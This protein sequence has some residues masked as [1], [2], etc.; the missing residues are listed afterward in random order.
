MRVDD[1]EELSVDQRKIRKIWSDISE[2][3]YISTNKDGDRINSF[4][5][6]W[7]LATGRRER[8]SKRYTKDKSWNGM[9]KEFEIRTNDDGTFKMKEMLKLY[10]EMK[11][12]AQIYLR[13]INT[14]HALW[15]ENPYDKAVCRDERNYLRIISA[16]SA[17]IQHIPPVMCLINHVEENDY[18]RDVIRRFLK[19]YNYILLRYKTIPVLVDS[20]PGI[21]GGDIYSK[22]Q[23]VEDWI[24]LIKK[25][26]LNNKN[27]QEEIAKLPLELENQV[28]DIDNFSW[29]ENH[30]E[31]AT[32]NQ[33]KKGTHK[34]RATKVRH[35]LFSLERALETQPSPKMARIH[36]KEIHAEHI[37]PQN[38][39][40]LLIEEDGHGCFIWPVS[41][42]DDDGKV[43]GRKF[44]KIHKRYIH[45]LGNKCILDDSVNSSIKDLNPA[46]KFSIKINNVEQPFKN[47]EFLTAR[48][49]HEIWQSAY[50]KIRVPPDW[51]PA[52]MEELSKLYMQKLIEFYQP[53]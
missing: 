40:G 11:K 28:S 33:Y 30:D 39:D 12:F 18:D 13:L 22:M 51:G 53:E 48:A 35:V 50:D 45:S 16:I 20:D 34:E 25:S 42:S 9:K 19:N 10:Q 43:A 26:D 24:S 21:K 14:R 46:S 27:E 1:G 41:E 31:W 15:N 17:E 23:G 4:F 8:P 47:S 49:A 37:V 38:T 2:D 5:F 6:N 44:I 32:V 52:E 7:L 36:P 29:I 3:L